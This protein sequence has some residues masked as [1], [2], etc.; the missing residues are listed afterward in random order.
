MKRKFPSAART[1]SPSFF[2]PHRTRERADIPACDSTS[3]ANPQG[4]RDDAEQLYGRLEM[5]EGGGEDKASA[6]APAV[7]ISYASQDAAA[8]AR[9][10]SALRQA[11]AE[12]WFDQSELRGGDVWHQRIRREIRVS[13]PGEIRTPDPQVRSL[14]LYPTELRARH[15]DS[16]SSPGRHPWST[17]AD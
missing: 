14:M 16:T 5:V 15:G 17:A 3:V 2:R 10:C 8:A 7:F 13:A 4:I 1:A 6:R 12:V 9:I 11:G